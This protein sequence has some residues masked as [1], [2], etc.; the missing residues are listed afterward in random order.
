[1][2]VFITVLQIIVWS[3]GLIT[4]GNAL[5]S[6]YLGK[7][8]VLPLFVTLGIFLFI[9]VV[10]YYYTRYKYKN[11]M[12]KVMFYCH[13]FNHEL[14]DRLIKIENGSHVDNYDDFMSEV[15]ELTKNSLNKLSSALGAYTGYDVCVHYKHIPF[16]NDID[17][18]EAP[19]LMTLSLCDN[20]RMLGDRHKVK[21]HLVSD[22]VSYGELYNEHVGHCYYPNFRRH[23]R[24]Y[25]K[26]MGGDFIKKNDK[27]DK[28][29]GSVAYVAVQREVSE[30]NFDVRGILV[31]D[32]RWPFV[33]LPLS[34]DRAI[35]TELMKTFAD[36]LYILMVKFNQAEKLNQKK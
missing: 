12:K 9:Y 10:M 21:E 30:D 29:Y 7:D 17:P 11:R 5:Y 27:V 22:S 15:K 33:F 34:R 24:R 2:N 14:R 36:G 31:A 25:K 20:T 3:C 4:G 13:Q 35:I 32:H 23:R 19:T 6:Y 18:D 28:Y 1:M 8:H 16:N 26:V